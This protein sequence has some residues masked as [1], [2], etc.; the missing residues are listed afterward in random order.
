MITI[1]VQELNELEKASKIF[2]LI[3]L[4]NPWTRLVSGYRD[5]ISDES[6]TGPSLKRMSHRLYREMHPEEADSDEEGS[7]AYPSFSEF[8]EYII[9]NGLGNSHFLPQHIFLCEESRYSYFGALELTNY[10]AQEVFRILN[11]TSSVIGSYDESSDPR[12]SRTTIIAK[13]LLNSLSAETA[14]KFYESFKADFLL[15]NYSN[16]TDPNFPLPLVS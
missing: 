14:E 15:L 11:V 13:Q 5:K 4:R 8:V 2:S 6:K 1:H 12:M 3:I 16:Y 7:T 10:H 9:N